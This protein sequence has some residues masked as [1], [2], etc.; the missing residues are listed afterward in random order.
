MAF[1]IEHSLK[2]AGYLGILL[3]VLLEN[4]VLFLFFLPSDSLLFTAGFLAS[5]GFF[6]IE[7]II[8][9]CFVGS[10]LGYMVGYSIGHKTGPMLFKD[11]NKSL[12]TVEH[13]EKAKKFYD[14]Y[15]SFALVLARFFPVRA[16]VCS[17][18]GASNL[19]YG[20]FMFYNVLGGAIWSISL[21]LIGFYFGKLFAPKD[22]HYFFAVVI[23][24]FVLVVAIIPFGV[25]YLRKKAK[26][27]QQPPQDPPEPSL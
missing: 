22:L 2:S 21:C 17:M 14:R 24:V 10:V 3:S 16:F 6:N 19:N 12:M 20:T 8:F 13:L 11:S 23:A 7:L 4:G 26:A 27:A 9:V 5:Q 25:N 18:A 1:D 15:A